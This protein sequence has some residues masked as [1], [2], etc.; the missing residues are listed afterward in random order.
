MQAVIR[1]AE[2]NDFVP[3]WSAPEKARSPRGTPAAIATS[4]AKVT[5]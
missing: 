4:R 1:P 5:V 2:V 3:S